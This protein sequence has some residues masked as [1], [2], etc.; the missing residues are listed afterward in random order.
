MGTGGRIFGGFFV[1]A[2]L[3]L[4]SCGKVDAVAS[5]N[6]P[7][8]TPEATSFTETVATSAG[9]LPLFDAHAH[10]MSTYPAGWLESLFT[11]HNPQGIVLLGVGNVFTHQENYPTK[12]FAFS[13]FKD[14]NAINFS[15]LESQ[16]DAGFRGIGE[17]SIRHFTTG[18]PESDTSSPVENDFNEPDLLEVYDKAKEHGVPVIFHF[19]YDTSHVEEIASTL[20]DYPE[21][22]FIWAHAGDAQP[23]ELWPLLLAHT[24][25]HL[26]ISC[27]NPLESYEGRLTSMALQRLDEEDGTLKST[28]KELFTEFADRIYFG[29]DIG[30]RGRLQQYGET[31]AY[32]RGILAQL[33]SDVAEKIAYKNAQELYG[34]S[35]PHLTSISISGSTVSMDFA[36]DAAMD[37]Q[38]QSTP[39]PASNTWTD[40]GSSQTTDGSGNVTFTSPAGSAG[41]FRTQRP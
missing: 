23:I 35:G 6:D 15:Q 16:L 24:N 26:D 37:Y 9:L 39:D 20:P 28:W 25:L 18:P 8:P 31:L 1:A 19:D 11:D 34:L 12:V 2:G 13:N 3:L 5:Q 32:Y 38:L 30:P 10:Q 41:A 4:M 17:V 22:T 40:E 36:G 21:V 27:R 29:S 33:E 7:E 14:V